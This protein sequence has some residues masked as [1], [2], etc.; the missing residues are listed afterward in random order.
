M[1]EVRERVVSGPLKRLISDAG[2]PG[3]LLPRKQTPKS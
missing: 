1:S 2:F 3:A